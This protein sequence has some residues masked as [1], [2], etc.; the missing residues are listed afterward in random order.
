M[1]SYWSDTTS[2]PSFSKLEKDIKVDVCIIGAGITGI[3]TAYMLL[4][5]GLKIALIDKGKICGRSN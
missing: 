5:S 2:C 4:D 1:E 3:M